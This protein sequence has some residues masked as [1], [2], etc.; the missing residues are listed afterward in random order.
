MRPITRA[1]SNDGGVFVSVEHERRGARLGNRRA[2]S[3]IATAGTARRA[4]GWRKRCS[5]SDALFACLLKALGTPFRA[6]FCCLRGAL[7]GTN[8][9]ESGRENKIRTCAAR[10]RR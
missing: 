3:S 1:A 4:R 7:G 9:L 8:N 6:P 2:T 10:T 5:D